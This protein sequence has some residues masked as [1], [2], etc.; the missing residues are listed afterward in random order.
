MLDGRE[1]EVR[2]E[3]LCKES[4]VQHLPNQ[5]Q[6]K[7]EKHASTAQPPMH[8]FPFFRCTMHIIGHF[9]IKLF[10]LYLFT[11]NNGNRVGNR[12]IILN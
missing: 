8:I 7:W 3:V 12:S 2:V 1:G 6:M 9:S 10:Y 11:P 4:K 5:Q